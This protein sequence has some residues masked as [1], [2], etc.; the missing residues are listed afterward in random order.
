[1]LLMQKKQARGCRTQSL[2]N[3]L[4]NVPNTQNSFEAKD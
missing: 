2:P 1:V 4:L 3:P